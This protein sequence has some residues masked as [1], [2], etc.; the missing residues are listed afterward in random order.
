M[1]EELTI[2]RE[3]KTYDNESVQWN[4]QYPIYLRSNSVIHIFLFQMCDTREVYSAADFKDTE[5]PEC[6]HFVVDDYRN[7]EAE[8]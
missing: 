2:L 8:T 5:T 4:S 7:D 3:D 1:T 6:Y